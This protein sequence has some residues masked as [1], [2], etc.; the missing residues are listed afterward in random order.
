MS[1]VTFSHVAAQ[2]APKSGTSN[3]KPSF[4]VTFADVSQLELLSKHST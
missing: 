1:E 3:E 2:T 4:L